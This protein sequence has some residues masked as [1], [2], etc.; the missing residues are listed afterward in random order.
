MSGAADL[1]RDTAVEPTGDGR[2]QARLPD[3][4]SFQLPS[5]GVLL[6]VALRAMRAAVPP[7]RRLLSATAI[8]C[9]PLRAGTLLVDLDVL[10]A[11]RTATQL[12]ATMRQPDVDG[13]MLVTATFGATRPGPDACGRRMPS[14]LLPP[15]LGPELLGGRRESAPRFFHNF[16]SRIALGHRWW[17]QGWEAGEARF[18]RWHRYLVPQ[19]VAD[20]HVDPLAI[21]P[22]AD[23]MPPSLKMLLGPGH[24]RFSAPSLDL[25]VHFLDDTDDEWLCTHT[26]CRRARDGYATA[27][28]EVWDRAGRLVAYGTQMMVIRYPPGG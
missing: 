18:A 12:S 20:G 25:T 2:Y 16:E 11:G 7:D 6:T 4:W 8:F 13:P 14:D 26:T 19:R 27:D 24:A 15:H 10:R 9:A 1:A 17:E 22:I 5:G 3:S 28:V 23:T 21:P